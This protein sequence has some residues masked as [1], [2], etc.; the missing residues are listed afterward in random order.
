MADG[1]HGMKK[2]DKDIF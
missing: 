2:A 1:G